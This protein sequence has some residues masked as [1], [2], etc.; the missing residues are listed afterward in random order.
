MF[1]VVLGVLGG[2]VVSHALAFTLFSPPTAWDPGANSARNFT[3]PSPGAAT[4]SIMGAGFVDASPMGSDSGHGANMTQSITAMGVLD[5]NTNMP[6]GIAD[7]AAVIDW[8]LGTWEAAS[9]FTNLGEVTDGGVDAGE[10]TLNGGHLGDIRVAAWNISTSN[11]QIPY[12]ALA[13]AFQP[14]TDSTPTAAM[15]GTIG[16]DIHFDTTFTWVDDPLDMVGNMQFDIYSVAL[17]EV[18]HS[19]GLDH[20]EGPS[21]PPNA[22]MNP[23]Y[24]GARRLLS[25][26]DING[27]QRLYGIPEPSTLSLAV[28]LLLGLAI[29]PRRRV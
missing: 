12:T 6:W 27:I 13:H 18:G 1:V 16:G 19:L 21:F 4:F 15:L 2:L 10:T 24:G 9:N 26:D 28:V 20:L 22:V 25:Q 7:Y 23:T 3:G 17:H 8:A 11:P 14:D 5:P 29:R